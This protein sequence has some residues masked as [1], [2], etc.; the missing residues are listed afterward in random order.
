[1][2]GAGL[3]RKVKASGHGH[4]TII[5]RYTAVFILQNTLSNKQARRKHVPAP[6]FGHFPLP[7]V[8]STEYNPQLYTDAVNPIRYGTYSGGLTVR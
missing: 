1:M 2:D 6:D 7:S 8:Y 4:Q 3:F 5:Q